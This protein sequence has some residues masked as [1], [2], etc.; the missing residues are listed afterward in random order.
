MKE[1]VNEIVISGY[2]GWLCSGQESRDFGKMTTSSGVVWVRR[3]RLHSLAVLAC[4]REDYLITHLLQQQEK[5][6][7]RVALPDKE[8]ENKTKNLG[9]LCK[10]DFVSFPKTTEGIFNTDCSVA[11][12]LDAIKKRHNI[13]LGGLH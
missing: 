8:G 7:I 1:G 5:M 12:L 13:S 6:F 10:Y 4:A 2:D 11:T 3:S 9:K